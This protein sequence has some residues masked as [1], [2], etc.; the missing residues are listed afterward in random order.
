MATLSL[1]VRGRGG[2]QTP[3][4]TFTPGLIPRHTA[5]LEHMIAATLPGNWLYLRSYRRA[6]A[7]ELDLLRPDAGDTILNVGCGAA[8][9]TA[10]LLARGCE[11]RVTA[12]DRD[13]AAVASARRLVQRLGLERQIEVVL[14]DFPAVAP[15]FTAAVV[16][17]QVTP[18]LEVLR[19][20][21]Q[22]AP[23]T[24]RIVMR[25]SA[26][27]CGQMYDQL[28]PGLVPAATAVQAKGAWAGSDLFI[29]EQVLRWQREES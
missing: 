17:L 1:Q 14:G 2:P 15:T 28:P 3:D 13:P 26:A 27:W 16:A 19:G 4:G 9:F 7:R 22:A 24:T 21:A 10:I 12:L 6:I 11:A 8:P 18:K 23:P 5:R 29:T 20:L 25:R